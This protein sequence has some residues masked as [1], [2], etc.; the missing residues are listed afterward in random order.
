VVAEA[1]APYVAHRH[2]LSREE[3]ARLIKELERQ[4]KEAARRL[5][6]EKA[7][8]LRDQ[9]YD[10]RRLLEDPDPVQRRGRP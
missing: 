3:A 9:I 2:S 10:L 1:K 6:F 4:M 7:A 5:E 8:L